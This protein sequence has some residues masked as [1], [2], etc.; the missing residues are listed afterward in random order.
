LRIGPDRLGDPLATIELRPDGGEGLVDSGV[1]QK[2]LKDDWCEGVLVEVGR[3]RQLPQQRARRGIQADQELLRLRNHLTNA[4]ERR[5]DRRP[6]PGPS[7]FHCQR[8]FPVAGV[9]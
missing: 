9:K 6:D 2:I 8:G 5:D 4:A 7:P 3:E 1:D